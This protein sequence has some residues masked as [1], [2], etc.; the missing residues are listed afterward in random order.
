[1]SCPAFSCGIY[2]LVTDMHAY[3]VHCIY[4]KLLSA[5]TIVSCARPSGEGVRSGLL[6]L[7]PAEC[8]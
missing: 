5:Q 8:N 1:M 4:F 7:V 2:A 6:R 3:F